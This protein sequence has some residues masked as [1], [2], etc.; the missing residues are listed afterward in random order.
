MREP[1]GFLFTDAVRLVTCPLCLSLE[2]ERCRQP[3]G[4]KA[5]T[6]HTQRLIELTEK[7]PDAVKAATGGRSV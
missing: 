1:S 4:R 7:R 2:G 5:N 6:P 3:S